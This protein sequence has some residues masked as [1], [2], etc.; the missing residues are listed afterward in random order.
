VLLGVEP[1]VLDEKGYAVN[2][3]LGVPPADD[4]RWPS[5]CVCGY[6]FRP[7]DV[8]QKWTEALFRRVGVDDFVTLREASPGAMWDASWLHRKG[9]D[10]RSLCVRLPDGREWWVD[11][12][13]TNGP[14]WERSG[15]PPNVT[16]T[17]SI[18]TPGYHGW[19]TDGVLSDPV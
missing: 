18:L 9:P 17:P 13:T 6:A 16:A 4:P 15:E 11:G 5:Q 1:E 19:L 2:G 12:P 14:G 8:T 7:D 3:S 10:G